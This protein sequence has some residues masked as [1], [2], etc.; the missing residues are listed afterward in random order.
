M[1]ESL[2]IK[3]FIIVDELEVSLKTGFSVLTGETGAG[4]SILIDALS[5]C[6][7]QRSDPSLVRKNK[8]KADIIATFNIEKNASIKSWLQE[9]D[10][11][12]DEYLI[13]RRVIQ[14]DGKSKA[15]INGVPTI[16]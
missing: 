15:F 16:L 9:K 10:L 5:L 12:S 2:T 13:L 4:K 1:L 11:L 6:L 14:A 8:E 3:D 7:G